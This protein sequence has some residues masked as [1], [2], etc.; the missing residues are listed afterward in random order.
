MNAL[1]ALGGVCVKVNRNEEVGSSVLKVLFSHLFTK[2]PGLLMKTWPQVAR[3]KAFQWSCLL[4]SSFFPYPF[5]FSLRSIPGACLVSKGLM[6]LWILRWMLKT[7]RNIS[8]SFSVSQK[9]LNTR[10]SI[11]GMI[12]CLTE[13][14]ICSQLANRDLFGQW[15]QS[16]TQQT[17]AFLLV[18]SR[19]N[20]TLVALL[21]DSNTTLERAFYTE[22]L[23]PTVT[24]QRVPT[25]FLEATS[26]YSQ[27]HSGS[28][29]ICKGLEENVMGNPQFSFVIID[30]EVTECFFFFFYQSA[31]WQ[32]EKYW[33]YSECNWLTLPLRSFGEEHRY[34]YRCN[35][36]EHQV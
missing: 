5:S 25:A 6:T 4:L 33:V 15:A 35:L 26:V 8:L 13:A 19:K 2:A 34:C 16:S 22:C 10:R 3:I 9:I 18:H 1:Y 36:E 7:E 17:P 31:R 14:A 29:F 28:T 24:I 27:F 21:P 11:Q 30:K 12:E 32:Q 23:C 20:Q